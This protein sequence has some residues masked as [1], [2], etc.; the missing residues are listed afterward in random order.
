MPKISVIIPAYNAEDCLLKS[1]KSVLCQ[2][3]ADLELI[4]VDDGS[5]DATAEICASLAERDGRGRVISQINSGVS[6]ARNAGMAAAK[7]EYI[8]FVD[9]D[10]V[11]EQGAYRKMR[12]AMESTGADCAMCG[13]WRTYPDG[14]R[15]EDPPPFESGRADWPEIREKLLIPLLADRISENLVLGTVWRYLFRRERIEALGLS[16]SGAYLEDELFLIEYFAEETSLACVS[17]PLYCYFQNP[18]SATRRYM[19]RLLETFMSSFRA[20]E[21]L[22]ERYD[23]APPDCWRDNTAWAG[24]LIAVGNEFA[25]G[26]AAG[27]RERIGNLKKL[28]AEPIF[29]HALK[30]YAPSGLNRN[31][32]LVARLLRRRMFFTLALLYTYKNRNRK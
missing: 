25:P 20:K 30:N 21:G 11:L 16:F 18:K 14:H 27:L 13:H 4:I 31:K 24:L 28:C 17:E 23:I 9:A 26:N 29:A 8:A 19:P 10:D 15:E 6:A 1:A 2:T 32:T 3:S 12:Q 5:T 22:V 7:G